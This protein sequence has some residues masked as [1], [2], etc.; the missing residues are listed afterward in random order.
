MADDK[1]STEARVYAAAD[2]LLLEHGGL[3]AVRL[4]DVVRRAGGRKQNV[5]R[6]LNRW[7]SDREMMAAR[8]P[9]PVLRAAYRFARDLLL[10]LTLS[11]Q[12]RARGAVTAPAA[13][14]RDD[15]PSSA[16]AP[17]PIPAPQPRATARRDPVP[18]SNAAALRQDLKP[19]G[20]PVGTAPNEPARRTFLAGYEE[21]VAARTSKPAVSARPPDAPKGRP[22]SWPTNRPSRPRRPP[23][24]RAIA[25][26]PESPV[27]KA[28]RLARIRAYVMRERAERADADPPMPVVDSDWQ[29]AAKPKVARAVAFELRAGRRPMAAKALISTGR[30]PLT[31]NRP[32]LDLAAALAG[33]RI[34]RVPGRRGAYWFDYE[35]AP[36]PKKVWASDDTDAKLAREFGRMLWVRMVVAIAVSPSPLARRDIAASLEPELSDLSP[37]WLAQCLKRG[38]KAGALDIRGGGYVI[39]RPRAARR[40]ARRMARRPSA[41][42]VER[43]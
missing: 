20:A 39:A 36:R 23:T 21:R 3:D 43:V 22:R 28:A 27:V 14:P 5:A 8:L 26:P 24:R 4:A 11:E 16:G 38:K 12:P 31:T 9:G 6:C 17:R 13:P 19:E 42:R 1:P 2:A 41:A 10:I 7:R 32:Y 34:A 18:R 25:R 30:I 29:G 33:S 15:Q 35:A 37:V 40:K